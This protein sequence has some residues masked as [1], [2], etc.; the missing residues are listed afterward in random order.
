[1][2]LSALYMG[3]MQMA[4]MRTNVDR[5][6]QIKNFQYMKSNHRL[7]QSN[8]Y[9]EQGKPVSKILKRPT[10]RHAQIPFVHCAQLVCRKWFSL[11]K[12]RGKVGGDLVIMC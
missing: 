10:G 2:R 7:V 9:P 1:M 5:Q 12:E 3:P 8:V 11:E 4:A 6:L